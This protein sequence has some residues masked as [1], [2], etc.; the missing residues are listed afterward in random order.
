VACKVV[1]TAGRTAERS[2]RIRC[3]DR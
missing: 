1:T 2:F 3:E